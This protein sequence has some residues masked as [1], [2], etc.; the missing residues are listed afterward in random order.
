MATQRIEEGDYGVEVVAQAAPEEK[1]ATPAAAE[2]PKAAPVTA[3]P[4]PQ[5]AKKAP[6]EVEELDE[7]EM[8]G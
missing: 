5:K 2:A 6:V 3:Q 4:A 8:Y 7:E 1:K